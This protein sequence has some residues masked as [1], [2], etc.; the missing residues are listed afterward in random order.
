MVHKTLNA[1][2]CVPIWG[3]YLRIPDRDII[4]V[5]AGKLAK[6]DRTIEINLDAMRYTHIIATNE[7]QRLS[8]VNI[9]RKHA[10]GEPIIFGNEG[11]D[12]AQA[13]VWNVGVDKDVVLNLQISKGK[14]WNECMTLLGINNAN[15]D[16]KERLVSSEVDAND[17]QVV[18]NRGI[19][20]NSRKIA[21]EQINRMFDLS[22]DVGWNGQVDAIAGQYASVSDI[23][24]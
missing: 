24:V 9:M 19:A 12:L 17:D 13:Q 1:K 22:L 8:W 2:E 4:Y 18:A 16:K 11:L 10:E 14:L 7:N 21:V 5:Y 15:Q 23:P 6:I 3:N 20:L